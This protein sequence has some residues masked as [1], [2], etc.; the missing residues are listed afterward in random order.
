[1][2]FHLFPRL[3]PNKYTEAKEKEETPTSSLI[4]MTMTFEVNKSLL[5]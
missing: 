5:K 3:L 4:P 2:E 1:M